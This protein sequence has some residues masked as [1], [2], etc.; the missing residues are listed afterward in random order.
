[1]SDLLADIA[2][3][4]MNR[5]TNELRRQARDPFR[6]AIMRLLAYRPSAEALQNFANKYPDKWASAVNA[7]A[8][9]AG[10]EKG[11]NV[12]LRLVPVD[13]MSDRDLLDEFIKAQARNAV[14]L[15]QGPAGE[16]VDAE[17]LPSLPVPVKK[18]GE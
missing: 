4:E 3:E 17:V 8:P 16:V 10:F 7:L 9:L 1:M 12:T 5:L 11:I 2:S 13:Q 15:A 6:R 18:A 14:A